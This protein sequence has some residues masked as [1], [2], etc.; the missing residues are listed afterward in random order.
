MSKWIIPTFFKK[1]TAVPMCHPC[2]A[3]ALFCYCLVFFQCRP[4]PSHFNDP[5]GQKK[6][7]DLVPPDS[8]HINFQNTVTYNEQFNVFT[9]RNFY[10]GGGVAIGD[11]NND[12]LP[13]IFFISNTG[14]NRLYLN[15]GNFT[16]RDITVPAGIL[17]KGK[18]STG[19]T[20][21][22]VNGDGLLDIYVCN[23]A[24]VQGDNKQNELY[25]NKG[26]LTFSEEALS[27]GL[28]DKGGKSTQAAFFDYDHDGDLDMFLLNNSFK[29]IGSF[30]LQQNE[31]AIRDSAGGQKL[32]RNDNGHFT[33]V[34]AA[35][36]IYGGRIAF[37]LGVSVGDINNDGWPDIY[38]CND[39]FERDYLYINQK[40]GTFRE[41]LEEQMHSISY[42]SMGSD[43]ADINNDGHLDIFVPE[44]LP[45]KEDRLKTNTTFE[46]WNKYQLNL[47]YDY[48]HQF[49]RNTLQ[50][51]NG[52]NTFSEIGRYAGVQATDWS[53]GALIADLDND[54]LKDIFISNGIYK[55]LTNGD[56]LQYISN[57]E[58]M[59]N[60]LDSKDRSRRLIEAMT[61]TPISNY[62][63]ANNGDLTF[64]DRAG[65]WGLGKPGFSN[66][67][68]YADLDNDGDLD[69]VVN[70]VNMPASVYRNNA[71]LRYPDRAYIKIRLLGQ[72]K[73]RFGVGA[74]VTVFTASGTFMQ[75]EM[76]VRGFQSSV[77]YCLNF[78]LGKV[79]KI[80]SVIVRW[81]D[82]KQ[83]RLAGLGIDTTLV[84][85]QNT[86]SPPLLPPQSARGPK[87]FF[88]ADSSTG[89]D[90]VH[91]ENGYSDFDEEPLRFQMLSTQG[92]A[93][94]TGDV[95][96]DGRM[97][98]YIGGARDQGGALYVQDDKGRFHRSNQKVWDAD[99]QCEDTY[100]LFFDA[101]GDGDNDLF[102]CSGSSE[103]SGKSQALAD[104]LYINDG[105]GNF[106]RS[107]QGL[108]DSS[109][110]YMS[111][112]CVAAA[113]YDGDG[114]ADLFV[115]I[116]SKPN[117]YG[118]PCK[119][120]ILH[121]NGKGQFTD[122]TAIVCPALLTAGMVTD[123]KWVDYDMDGR[124]DLV[125]TGEYMP[126]RIF[127]NDGGHFTERTGDAGL[128]SSNGWWNRLEIADLDNDGY[129]DIIAGN[130]G[131]NSR[132]KAS[133]T[134]PVSMYA[135][136]FDH[137]GT[138]EQVIT[139]YNG[140]TAYPMSLRHDL[141]AVLPYLKKRFLRYES[142][143]LQ[144]M[145][146]IF[147]PGQLKEA[148]RCD[149]YRMAS[150]V[151]MN[152]RNG[153]FRIG[154]LPGPAQ[155]SPVYGIS[156]LDV[157]GD[158]NKDL[159]LG[160]NFFESK[161]EA[162]I[163]DASF[164]LLLVGD[165]KG[166]FTPVPASRSG[167][168]IRGAVRQIRSVIIGKHSYLV[169]AMNNEKVRLLRYEY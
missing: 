54:G 167:I 43:M 128:A 64:T 117:A 126:I 95:N 114:A 104:R 159:V 83:S 118:Y 149:A 151:L 7:F 162:G 40:N 69:L 98:I 132:F 57:G 18:W 16:F 6:L 50:L 131:L 88:S 11:I 73:N 72:G 91:R 138:V 39:F 155:F 108:P 160:G 125:V 75:E 142:Y 45:E 26:D 112:S 99:K 96:N 119:S 58:V 38:V 153:T 147:T 5:A 127:H 79:K 2:K 41:S 139:C 8:S 86:A 47:R 19:V 121:N 62:A 61:S 15:L 60:I 141:V 137:N 53:W 35:A 146:D 1:K 87:P 164:G 28:A 116:R 144:T 133:P 89:L 100:A 85:Q 30:N 103:F 120:T 31:R 101:D 4:G 37:G 65:E 140:D 20:M 9:Y 105:K 97:D 66:G 143:K 55:D 106:T 63:Y 56:Y 115:G 157:N 169:L 46:N 68:A 81:N 163:Y 84:I 12:G 165:G 76:P 82:G 152:Q 32:F 44:M 161:P 111:S 124:I 123:A 94:A 42:S 109:G 110:N 67:A 21:A 10:N 51:N 166:N 156:V 122:V 92:P 24:D 129:P 107:A 102:I 90:F 145:A 33:D 148:V 34:S 52:D 154:A 130:H 25:I 70:N 135:S 36:G 3:F 136:D 48:Y 78:G 49:S 27:Y 29:L 74:R 134:K 13:D 150:S 80:D 23:S 17:K 71:T 158:G 77:D 59:K 22:D 14:P 168:N 93:L 113:D